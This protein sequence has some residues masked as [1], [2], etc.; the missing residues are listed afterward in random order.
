MKSSY[1]ILIC[2][3]IAAKAQD[4]PEDAASP[5]CNDNQVACKDPSFG[6]Y[7]MEKGN[8]GLDMDGNE[9][10]THCPS[11]C[12]NGEIYCGGGTDDNNCPKPDFCI[13]D[14]GTTGEN[15]FPCPT[16]CPVNCAGDQI[17]CK[18][19]KN[20]LGCEDPPVCQSPTETGC[21]AICPASCGPEE[22]A[23]SGGVDENNCPKPQICVS[24]PKEKG[25]NGADCDAFC[26]TK[27]DPGQIACP[28]END[29]WTG[30]PVADGCFSDYEVT[31]S[32]GES[33][34]C[35]AF[36]PALCSNGQTMCPGGMDENTC[37][38]ADFCIADG[39]SCN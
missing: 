4:C 31:N 1:G 15:G 24:K 16:H 14:L 34:T 3:L 26:E 38:I 39:G 25:K 23:C 37:P 20:F 5:N 22:K 30:C 28:Q 9:C 29:Y 19:G 11:S 36:C 21:P 8:S 6:C 27:C 18:G 12:D 13:K 33:I 32:N 2:F 10:E 35:K 17:E 7:C